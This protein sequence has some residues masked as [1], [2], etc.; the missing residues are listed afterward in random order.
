[1]SAHDEPELRWLGALICLASAAVMVALLR[2][3]WR[4]LS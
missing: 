2:A 4:L 3:V 1:M